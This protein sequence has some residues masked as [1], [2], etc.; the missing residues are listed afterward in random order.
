MIRQLLASAAVVASMAFSMN[1]EKTVL[2]TANAPEG[3]PIE[4]W[5]E[6]FKM[7]AEESAVLNAGDIIT[8]SITAKGNT[9][10]P[11]VGIF[12]GDTGWP[13][14]AS[15]GAGDVPN[16]VDLAISAEIA[17][18]IHANGFSI[19]GESIYV[20]EIYYEKTS[21][22]VGPNT[23][24]F[25]PK[26]CNWGDPV[27]ISKD[28]FA[29]VKAGDQI[30]VNYDKE[31]PEHTLQFLFG[32]WSGANIPTYEAWKTDFM[33]IDEETGWIT[34]D[35]KAELANLEWEVEGENK[36]YDIFALLKEGGLLMQGPCLVNKV[37]FNPAPEE[38]TPAVNYYAVGGFQDWNV[39]EPAE[40]TYADGV[41][42]LVAE[43]AS[44]MKISTQAGNWDDFNSATIGPDGEAQDGVMPF[45]VR[46]NYEF[47]LDYQANW[48]VTIDPA[49]QTIKFFTEDSRPEAEIYLRGG[50]NGWEAVDDWKFSTADGNV[51]TLDNVSIEAGV[52]FKVADA[53]WGTVNYGGVEGIEP[54]T[55][56]TL[57]Y[58]VGNCSLSETVENAIVEFNLTDKALTVKTST[59]IN[60]ID[61]DNASAVYFNL[62]GV[63]VANPTEGNI[64][65]VKKGTKVSKTA[66]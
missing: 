4:G 37:D 58:N 22:E 44:T 42:T 25:G 3:A 53:G 12:E 14:M 48:T 1:A 34:I 8:V 62:Q 64:Y 45:A 10:W 2:W 13:P 40:F 46:T 54:N 52:E 7:S 39:E 50:M 24:W 30:K 26:Q 27:S 38:P 59:G 19:R 11:Q 9:G 31:A 49:K 63:R 66:F 6:F 56:V 16:N 32:G 35:L 5:N 47:V 17:D 28:V 15:V 51:Y 41:F 61:S 57:I 60:A 21:I 43:G 18:K 65:I 20:D 36:E 23:V 29:D 33:T 55:T